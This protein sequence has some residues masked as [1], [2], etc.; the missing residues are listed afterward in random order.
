M[1]NQK[2]KKLK[3]NCFV[4]A[5]LIAIQLGI[6]GISLYFSYPVLTLIVGICIV[7]TISSFLISYR[8]YKK[9]YEIDHD[10]QEVI[11]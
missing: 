11:K 7:I 3:Y 2:L 8:C 6:V 10:T 4:C 9:S 5:I 1:N